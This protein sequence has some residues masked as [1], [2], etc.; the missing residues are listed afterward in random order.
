M[1]Q[2]AYHIYMLLGRDGDL[3]TVERAS[4]N[5]PLG[6]LC[7]DNRQYCNTCCDNTVST[8][9]NLYLYS[10]C[11]KSASCTHALVTVTPT[12]F[13]DHS[14]GGEK[15]EAEE[16]LPVLCPSMETSTQEKGEQFEDISDKV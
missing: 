3:A 13:P 2:G 15:P 5:V 9:L 12:R 6:K 1:K 14:S 4:L 16:V 11:R 7:Y 10:F 8:W